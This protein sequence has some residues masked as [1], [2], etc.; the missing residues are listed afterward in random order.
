MNIYKY[1]LRANY[2]STL[3]WCISI[4]AMIV[5]F[6]YI[7]PSYSIHKDI[8]VKMLAGFPPQVLD[9]FGIDVDQLFSV[10]GFYVFIFLYITLCGSI[11][12]SMLSITIMTKEQ[13][14]KTSDFLMTKPV[15]R[16]RIFLSKLSAILTLLCSSWILLMIAIFITVS[17]YTMIQSEVTDI[18]LISA[19]LLYVQLVFVA[20]SCFIVSF[21]KRVKSVVNTSFA[22]VFSFFLVG[23]VDSFIDK[24]LIQYIT[25]FKLFDYQRILVNHS[26]DLTMVAYGIVMGLVMMLIS[27]VIY[28]KKDIHMV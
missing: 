5:V 21:M 6:M 22:I 2:R 25:P 15:S 17:N 14:M 26:I 20:I 18:M 23:V 27:Y 13:R 11:Q 4:L 12:S 9:V 19:T 8:V 3:Y 24:G 10:P 7:Y 1:E 28:K 16:S